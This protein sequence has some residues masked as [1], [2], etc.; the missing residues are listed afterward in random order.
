MGK[1]LYPSDTLKQ[2][3]RIASAWQEIEPTLQIGK[4]TLQAFEADMQAVQDLQQK[5]IQLQH[6]LVEVR[7][8]RDEIGI[9]LWDHI[10]RTRSFIKGVYGADSTEYELA[11]GT[12][13][14]ERKKPRRRIFPPIS[15]TSS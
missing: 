9:G 12:R 1:K 14:S 13:K 2:A 15:H 8:R 5:I 6:E 7:N 10:T 11:G 4:L 3:L